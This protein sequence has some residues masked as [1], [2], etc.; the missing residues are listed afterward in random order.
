MPAQYLRP[1]LSKLTSRAT[2]QRSTVMQSVISGQ[3][4]ATVLCSISPKYRH[5]GHTE[6]QD[7]CLLAYCEGILGHSRRSDGGVLI[8]VPQ[9]ACCNCWQEILQGDAVMSPI[10]TAMQ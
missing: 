7:G 3:V 5:C 2:L 4:T 8:Q 9:V 10:H 1:S 6:L